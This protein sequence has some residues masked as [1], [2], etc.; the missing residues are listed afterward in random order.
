MPE[1]TLT[2]IRDGFTRIA[3]TDGVS[4]ED[5]AESTLDLT[6]SRPSRGAVLRALGHLESGGEARWDGLLWYHVD[7]DGARR[8]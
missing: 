3:T 4:L 5:V 8:A 6:G 2:E 7:T 1:H